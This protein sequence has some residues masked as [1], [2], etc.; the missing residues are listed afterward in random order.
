[1]LRLSIFVLFLLINNVKTLMQPIVSQSM[2]GKHTL[3]H[4]IDKSVKGTI[5]RSSSGFEYRTRALVPLLLSY[6]SHLGRNTHSRRIVSSP[7]KYHTG[8]MQQHHTQI[9]CTDYLCWVNC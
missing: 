6:D 5:Y 4:R 2:K 9:E 3:S 8:R 1:M 7:Q